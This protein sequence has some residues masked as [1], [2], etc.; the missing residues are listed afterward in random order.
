MLTV[1][2]GNDRGEQADRQQ[3]MKQYCQ[4]L[5]RFGN[6]QACRQPPLF[7]GTGDEPAK[8]VR[9]AAGALIML[10]LA[11]G[12]KITFVVGALRPVAFA[13]PAILALSAPVVSRRNQTYGYAVGLRFHPQGFRVSFD[14]VLAGSIG[15]L[16]GNAEQSV[17]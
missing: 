4:L 5:V 1:I 10:D 2:P 15:A 8:A 11:D 7:Q 3:F 9:I 17:H 13:V 14:G 6:Q 12:F 16:E